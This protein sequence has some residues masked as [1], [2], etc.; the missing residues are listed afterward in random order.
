MYAESDLALTL[1]PLRLLRVLVAVLATAAVGF[2]A[3]GAFPSRPGYGDTFPA[4]VSGRL[5]SVN[6]D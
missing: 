2:D 3:G 5:H 1:P 6:P 4:A